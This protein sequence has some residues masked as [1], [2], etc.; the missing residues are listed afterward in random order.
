MMRNRSS[1]ISV[2]VLL[3]AVPS[4][5]GQSVADVAR[6]NRPKDAKITSQRVFTDDDVKHADSKLFDLSPLQLSLLPKNQVEVVKQE[7]RKFEGKTD[8]QLADDV[9]R[10][11]QFPERPE[12]EHRLGVQAK[13]IIATTHVLLDLIAS[14]SSDQDMRTSA[15]LD[16]QVAL[17]GYDDLKTE[18]IAKAAAWKR[19]R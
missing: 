10:D 7:L 13:K 18:G 19:N 6:H 5:F 9:V 2:F 8:R 16:T 17:N 12:W 3:F 15:A 14:D 4:V 11:I 1:L